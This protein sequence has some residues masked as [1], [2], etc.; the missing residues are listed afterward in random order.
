MNVLIVLAPNAE[1]ADAAQDTGL[2]ADAM[3]ELTGALSNLGLVVD[4]MK[5]EP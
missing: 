4:V 3:G 2:T 5:D 1:C